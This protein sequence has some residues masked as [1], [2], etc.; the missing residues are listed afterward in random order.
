MWGHEPRPGRCLPIGLLEIMASVGCGGA[1]Q[2]P[3][4]VSGAG[5][6]SAREPGGEEQCPNQQGHDGDESHPEEAL[7]AE[8]IPDLGDERCGQ[9]DTRSEDAESPDR[10]KADE[11]ECGEAASAW[12]AVGRVLGWILA[13]HGLVVGRGCLDPMLW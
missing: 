10:H 4:L 3:R 8:A 2:F 11:A 6:F 5:H 12:D 7:A 1:K 9:R 13:G